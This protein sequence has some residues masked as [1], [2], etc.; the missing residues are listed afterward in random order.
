[1]LQYLF[2][3]KCIKPACLAELL[4]TKRRSQKLSVTNRPE[5][6]TKKRTYNFNLPLFQ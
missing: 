1:M 2:A 4:R 6:D 3:Q 5:M